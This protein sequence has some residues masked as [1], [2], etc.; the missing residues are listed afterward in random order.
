M[1]LLLSCLCL[2]ASLAAE[3]LPIDLASASYATS[4]FAEL[5]ESSDGIDAHASPPEAL[6]L[7]SHAL[8]ENDGGD[9]AAAD[10]LADAGFLS[11]S[12]EVASDLAVTG[13]V[14]EATLRAELDQPGDYL[15][16]LVFESVVEQAGLGTASAVL[17]LSLDI[18]GVLLFDEQFD[19]AGE[20]LRAFTLAPGQLAILDLHLLALGD[21]QPPEDGGLPRV[22]NADSAFALASVQAELDVNPVPTPGTLSLLS[23]A[24]LPLAARRMRR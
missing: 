3:A 8:L 14:A 21:A 10:A 9:F 1:R 13:A 15:L 12:T 5:G 2:L 20:I 16:R 4:A 18:A 22:R 6:P 11:V 7:A 24:L 19:A 23:V 17:G